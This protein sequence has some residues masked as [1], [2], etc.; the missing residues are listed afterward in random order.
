MIRYLNI[1]RFMIRVFPSLFLI[2]ITQIVSG[3][4][5]PLFS[6]YVMNGFLVNPSLAGR[7]GYSSIN[8]TAREQWMGI[9]DGP[10]TF[11]V[12]FQTTLLRNSFIFPQNHI[13]K[14]AT[15]PTKPSRVGLGGS[16]Y[17]DVNGIMRRTGFKFDYAYHLPLGK[18]REGQDNLSFGLGVIMYQHALRPGDLNYSYEDD[19]YFSNY[20]KSVFITDFSFGAN[21][22]TSKYYLGFSM[23]NILRG[24]LIFGN[25][26]TEKRGELGHYFLTGG[27]NFPL[28][29]EWTVIP[30]ALVRSS[31]LLFKSI[32]MDL[33]TRVFYKENYWG[34]LSYRTN[35]ALILLL[36]MRY[37]RFYIANSF[38]LVLTDIKTR[39]IGSYEISVAIKFGES[40]R[41][42]RWLN[43]Y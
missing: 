22:T 10:S 11:V 32:Q 12:N 38:D 39:S 27:M 33:T 6:Q 43:S 4:Q 15:R 16:L 9:K 42:Y 13:R 19:P 8:F 34:G 14:K 28:N 23:T 21:Y 1:Y 30:S 7:D 35:D 37:D 18:L 17:N 5:L 31:D 26:N 40:S 20:D 41:R 24:S 29:K 25:D 2:F 3:Q 36:G